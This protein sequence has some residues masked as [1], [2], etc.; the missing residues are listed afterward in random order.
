MVWDERMTVTFHDDSH[1]MWNWT[2][3]DGILK[4]L[5]GGKQK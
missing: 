4:T 2:K 3:Q 1:M 5:K